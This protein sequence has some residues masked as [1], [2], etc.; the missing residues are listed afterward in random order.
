MVS[1]ALAET[2]PNLANSE[3]HGQFGGKGGPRSTGE[4]AFG[5]AYRLTPVPLASGQKG[6][7]IKPPGQCSELRF[8]LASRS[9]EA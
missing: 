2:P 3:P 5:P 9:V 7:G 6:S 1:P 4:A 8:R